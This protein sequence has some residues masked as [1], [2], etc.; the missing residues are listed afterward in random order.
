[1][2]MLALVVFLEQLIVKNQQECEEAQRKL[3][4]SKNALSA[5]LFIEK[6][7]KDRMIKYLAC[8]H[9]IRSNWR[10]LKADLL[11]PNIFFA[12][13]CVDVSIHFSP[14]RPLPVNHQSSQN[15]LVGL[16]HISAF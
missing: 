8:M 7:M 2:R 5:L 3:I 12:R 4:V 15:T 9:V 10:N 13:F 1:M 16:Y 6:K 11:D 14:I